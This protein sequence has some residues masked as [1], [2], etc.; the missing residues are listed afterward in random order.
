MEILFANA[1]AADARV[2]ATYPGTHNPF[3]YGCKKT[4]LFSFLIDL[5]IWVSL[6]NSRF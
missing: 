1:C 5:L 6:E 3:V 4:I 2:H